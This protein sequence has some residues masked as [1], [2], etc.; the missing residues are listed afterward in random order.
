VLIKTEQALFSNVAKIHS[1]AGK[2][3]ELWQGEH[4]E[5]KRRFTPA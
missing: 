4:A 3:G 5:K 1:V 2:G